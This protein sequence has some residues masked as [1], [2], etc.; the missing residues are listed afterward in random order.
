MIELLEKAV[1]RTI[2][3]IEEKSGEIII[4]ERDFSKADEYR[5]KEA[6]LNMITLKLQDIMDNLSIESEY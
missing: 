5:K 2:N 6:V 1:E 3:T 4:K